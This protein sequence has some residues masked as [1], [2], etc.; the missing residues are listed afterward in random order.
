MEYQLLGNTGLKVSR[1]CFGGLTV[2]PLQA[3]L[4]IEAGAEVMAEAFVKGVNFIDTAELYETYPYIKLA[5]EVYSGKDIVI[6]SK[7]YAYD[8]ETAKRSL[9]KALTDMKIDKIGVFL[10]HEQE[11]EHTI[12]GHF[13]A[14]MYYLKMKEE[15]IIKAVGLSTHTVRAVKA[16]GSM[17]EIDVVHPIFNKYGIGI[18]DGT[19]DEMLIAIKQAYLNGKGIYGMK[20]IGGGNLIQMADECLDYVLDIP[21]LHSIAVGMQSKEEVEAN[22]LKFSYQNVPD[23]VKNK[24]ATKKRKLQIEFW[25]TNCG[26]CVQHCKH[27]ALASGKDRVSVNMETCVLCGY[28]SRYCPQFCIKIV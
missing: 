8:K 13:D 2:G 23:A 18:Q 12:R 15:G 11:S 3:N 10:L 5:L 6:A 28:C 25:C 27:G 14:L 9:D 21:Y 26:N 1:L 19:R 7:S 24:I 16:A 20:P 22:I 17:N 4:S